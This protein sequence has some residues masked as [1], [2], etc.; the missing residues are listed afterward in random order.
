MKKIITA[1][2]L[3]CAMLF[4]SGAAVAD[5]KNPKIGLIKFRFLE[6]LRGKI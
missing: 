1:I 4:G 6:A 3:G 2:G 5:A